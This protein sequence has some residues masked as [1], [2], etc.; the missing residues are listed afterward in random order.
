MGVRGELREHWE[1]VLPC[2]RAHRSY[3]GLLWRAARWIWGVISGPR[4]CGWYGVRIVAQKQRNIKCKVYR[5]HIM[6]CIVAQLLAVVWWS[7][8]PRAHAGSRT[9]ARMR[10]WSGGLSALVGF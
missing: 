9:V 5:E 2:T 6:F 10:A 8:A 7:C 4:G 1:F 3:G